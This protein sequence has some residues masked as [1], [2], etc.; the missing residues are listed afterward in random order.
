MFVKKETSDSPVYNHFH[1]QLLNLDTKLRQAFC[2]I[3][4]EFE[5]HLEAINENTDEL[6][7]F[8]RYLCDMD[9]KIEKLNERL[10][11]V[12]LEIRQIAADKRDIILSIAEQKVFLML[13]TFE[14]GFLS[15]EDI[16]CRS[17]IATEEVRQ[18]LSS[19]LDKGVTLVREIAEGSVFFKLNPNFKAKQVREQVVKI[20][21]SVVHQCQNRALGA[22]F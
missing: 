12:H 2:T 7:S 19:M 10:D 1:N 4:E 13:Y 6:T 18:V 5:D 3:K 11:S 14:N 17:G 21:P 20:D 9:T 8:H 22:F 15:V 16:A